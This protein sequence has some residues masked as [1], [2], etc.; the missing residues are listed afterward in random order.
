MAV[1]GLDA[2]PVGLDGAHGLVQLVGVLPRFIVE[3][4]TPVVLRGRYYPDVVC[5]RRLVLVSA[6]EQRLPIFCANEPGYF[7]LSF[8]IVSSII[9]YFASSRNVLPE[10]RKSLGVALVVVQSG[11]LCGERP[12]V[13]KRLLH[14]QRRLQLRL[15]DGG[16]VRPHL[17]VEGTL[18]VLHGV[19]KCI[20]DLQISSALHTTMRVGKLMRTNKPADRA[21]SISLG[22]RWRRRG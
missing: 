1:A 19:L 21:C 16:H 15:G 4:V 12:D 13:S 2:L 7:S 14:R 10:R 20:G 18:Q 9:R 8:Q 3:A 22:G 17:F 5:R 11:H 6:K